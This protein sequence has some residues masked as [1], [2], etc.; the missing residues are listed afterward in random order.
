MALPLPL[1][2]TALCLL[3][4]LTTVSPVSAE[5]DAA[6]IARD[7]RIEQLEKT[8][9]LLANELA[10]V[11]TQVA[12]PEEAEL[13]P[14]Y[15]L[16]P[17]ASKVY[18]VD[19]GLSIGG[20][21]EI[22]YT[23]FVGDEGSTPDLDRADALRTVLYLGYKFSESIVFN[24]EI[25]FEHG[26]TSNVQNG[27]GG[28]SVS[29][30]LASLDFFYT[31]ELN[32]RAGLLLAPMGFVNEVHEPPFF[33]GVQRPEVERR[34]IPSTWR[35][36][37]AGIFGQLGENF[38]YRAYLMTGF[39]GARFSDAGF[40]DGRQKGNRALAED[41]AIVLRADY[42]CDCLAGLEFGGSIYHGDVDQDT[43]LTLVNSGAPTATGRPLTDARLTM[44]EGHLQYRNGGL[45]T[46]L[47][48]AWTHLAGA[49]DFNTA[50]GRSTSAA[51]AENMF[52][53][54][55][56]VAYDIWPLLFGGEAKALEPFVR[57]EYVD[58]QYRV[59][60]GFIANR[61]RAYWVHTGGI[62]YSPHPNV[63][64][65]VEYRNLNARGGTRPDELALG[66][67]FAF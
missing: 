66:V 59:P 58:T 25:E 45:S 26:S 60:S 57:V 64:L 67:G 42:R 20:Y 23:N 37:G 61:N 17:A 55:A 44:A 41:F 33:F 11:R 12:V 31:P 1:R 32:F 28:G 38:E 14:A 16:G 24:S 18:G 19:R 34:I 52:G 22:N 10:S 36:I 50:L 4:T 39:N 21:G 46:R 13:I 35:N 6:T 8:V 49:A 65:K 27:N 40:R 43:G 48:A 30:E 5:E 47:L 53:A 15:G 9:Q 51:I 3:V 63:V 29:V 62:N 7:D 56:E 54:Y 2:T